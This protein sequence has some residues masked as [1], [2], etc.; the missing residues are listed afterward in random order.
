M[1][2]PISTGVRCNCTAIPCASIRCILRCAAS[3]HLGRRRRDVGVAWPNVLGHYA[4]PIHR[5]LGQ[6]WAL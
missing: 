4:V 2:M 6:C 1:I 3:R 5:Q